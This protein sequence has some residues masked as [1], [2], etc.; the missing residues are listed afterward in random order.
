M[1]LKFLFYGN[2]KSAEIEEKEVPE[3]ARAISG[4]EG[5]E[6]AGK[7]GIWEFRGGAFKRESAALGAIWAK[8]WGNCFLPIKIRNFIK[9]Q[10]NFSKK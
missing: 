4:R 2:E 3:T 10:K 8:G 9:R 1:Y 5:F 7:G 6:R